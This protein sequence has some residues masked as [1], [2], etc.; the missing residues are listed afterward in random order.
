MRIAEILREAT[1][2]YLNYIYLRWVE[3]EH[4]V[5]SD[6]DAVLIECE[7]IEK[8]L[9]TLSGRDAEEAESIEIAISSFQELIARAQAIIRRRD[10]SA[11]GI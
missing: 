10:G 1:E 3:L 2:D 5:P 7:F 9:L 11:T 4:Q 6:P 8:R